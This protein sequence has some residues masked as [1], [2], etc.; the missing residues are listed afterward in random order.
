[1][2]DDNDVVDLTKAQ[3]IVKSSNLENVFDKYSVVGVERCSQVK[4]NYKVNWIQI[5]I[6]IIAVFIGV[7]SFI[8]AIFLCC[9]YRKYVN[10]V[11]IVN[12]GSL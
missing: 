4:S 12:I 3:D 10:F 2:V 6:L 1:M 9:L 8:A 11:R 5:C 7:A